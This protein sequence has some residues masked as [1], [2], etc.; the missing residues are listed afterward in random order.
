MRG[1]EKDRISEAIRQLVDRL[2]PTFSHLRGEL[3]EHLRAGL[4]P[5]L[6]KMNLVS[7]EEYDIQ[8]ALLERLR[9]RVAQLE[10][11][12]DRERDKDSG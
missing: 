5:M 12:L 9:K 4:E 10:K 8:V 7:R 2:P 11:R 3:S 1:D 6:H